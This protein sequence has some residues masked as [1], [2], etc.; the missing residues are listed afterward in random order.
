MAILHMSFAKRFST[1]LAVFE[2]TTEKT[3]EI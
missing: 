3:E 1:P 2:V